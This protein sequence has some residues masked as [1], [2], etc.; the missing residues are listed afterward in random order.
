ML[1]ETKVDEKDILKKI[2]TTESAKYFSELLEQ[3]STF[4]LNGEWGMGKTEFLK[5][6]ESCSKKN[7]INLNLWAIKDDRTVINI[8]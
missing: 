7:F 2:D 3:N 1:S 4:F 5:G 8:A 6:V